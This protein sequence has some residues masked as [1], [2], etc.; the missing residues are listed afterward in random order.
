MKFSVAEEHGPRTDRLDFGDD[1]EQYLADP[2]YL[3]PDHDRDS[4]FLKDSLCTIE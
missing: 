4:G 3:E 2:W 1:P